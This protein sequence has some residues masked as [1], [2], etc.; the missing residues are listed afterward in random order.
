MAQGDLDDFLC[1]QN[2]LIYWQSVDLKISAKMRNLALGKMYIKY[3]LLIENLGAKLARGLVL[4]NTVSF[5]L[6][7]L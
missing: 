3:V 1:K 5:T 7:E 2:L 6:N 4:H